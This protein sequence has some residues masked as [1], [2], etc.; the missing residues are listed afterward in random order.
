MSEESSTPAG[1]PSFS[2]YHHVIRQTTEDK[3]TRQY[4]QKAPLETEDLIGMYCIMAN[5]T[6]NPDA[7]VPALPTK[8]IT[9]KRPRDDT[10]DEAQS[11]KAAKAERIKVLQVRHFFFFFFVHRDDRLTFTG[12]ERCHSGRNR[13]SERRN[14]R[15]Q[16]QGRDER[17]G[18]G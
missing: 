3:L 2:M 1:K 18:R 8:T 9:T 16:G 13:C 5:E 4:R 11:K 17:D 15:R 14:C 10:S 7:S 12:Q 6:L